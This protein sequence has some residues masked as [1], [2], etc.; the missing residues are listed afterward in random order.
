MSWT[1]CLQK[2]GSMREN[3]KKARQEAGMTQKQVAEYL[4]ITEQHYQKIEYGTV[5]GKIELWDA[6]E[7]LFEIHQRMLREMK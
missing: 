1:S 6:L 7:D 5:N 4:G 3:L 2:E